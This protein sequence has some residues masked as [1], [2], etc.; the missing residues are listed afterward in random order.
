[1][2]RENREQSAFEDIYE[3]LVNQFIAKGIAEDKARK[4]ASAYMEDIE[5]N[6]DEE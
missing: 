3:E 2:S 6:E 5:E 4:L 1:M